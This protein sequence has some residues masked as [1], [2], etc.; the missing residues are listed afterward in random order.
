[1]YSIQS[2]LF[3]HFQLKIKDKITIYHPFSLILILFFTS[4]S[5]PIHSSCFI[6]KH[7]KKKKEKRGKQHMTDLK[8]K[9]EL[10]E[11]KANEV[12]EG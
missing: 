4:F 10:D 9:M 3:L 7:I 5:F 8:G 11:E 6:L 12:G 2:I 1:M